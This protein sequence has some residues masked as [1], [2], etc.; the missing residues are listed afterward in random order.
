MARGD[1][2]GTGTGR[3]SDVAACAVLWGRFNPVPVGKPLALSAAVTCCHVKSG[4]GKRVLSSGV[5]A[6]SPF[7]QA[8]GNG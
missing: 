6:R 1:E 8:M 3:Y 7:E 5:G 2:T 4:S